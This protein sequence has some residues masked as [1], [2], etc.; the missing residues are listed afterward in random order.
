MSTP[1]TRHGRRAEGFT[2]I[3][4][5]VVV[6]IIA[7][8]ISI[9]LPSL[10]RAREQAKATACTSNLHQLAVAA[11]Y[12]ID[13]NDS[14]IPYI[15]G[16]QGDANQPVVAPFA[17]TD[18]IYHFW[19]YIKN[20]KIY[21]CPS[22]KGYNSTKWYY[23]TGQAPHFIGEGGGRGSIYCV[24]WLSDENF[25]NIAKPNNW[26]PFIDVN[27]LN[28]NKWWLPDVYTEYFFNDWQGARDNIHNLDVPG[29]S[30]AKLSQMAV[31]NQ[32]VLFND[33]RHDIVQRDRVDVILRNAKRLRHFESGDFA[34]L[35]GHV[36]RIRWINFM[37]VYTAKVTPNEKPKDTDQW[38]NRPFWCWGVMKPGWDSQPSGG[39]NNEEP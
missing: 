12:Y 21:I 3:E 18:I 28:E 16:S 26:W 10:G 25:V 36:D 33:G 19:K 11:T 24:D 7:L 9:L 1:H 37:D 2:L 22:A 29:I 34:F 14:R 15:R 30:G 13:E 38:G 4:L 32:V 27:A 5:L 35:D 23:D 17:Q 31:P 6:A 20:L 8:L 39:S